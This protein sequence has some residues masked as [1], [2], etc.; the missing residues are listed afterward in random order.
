MP[1]DLSTIF[2]E[3]HRFARGGGAADTG[4][5]TRIRGLM[6]QLLQSGGLSDY[7]REKLRDALHWFEVLYSN[8]RHR[9]WIGPLTDGASVVRAYLNGDLTAAQREIERGTE[10][11]MKG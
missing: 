6:D 7:A 3:L 11:P 10:V 4:A 5:I 9:R 2:D 8:D 1:P